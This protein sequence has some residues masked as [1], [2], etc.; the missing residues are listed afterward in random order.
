[1]INPLNTKPLKFWTLNPLYIVL[2]VN[3]NIFQINQELPIWWYVSIFRNAFL[4]KT[5]P[6]KETTVFCEYFQ[7]GILGHMEHIDRTSL[8][9]T[10]HN[11]RLL[12][13]LKEITLHFIAEN[14]YKNRKKLNIWK[15]Y[16]SISFDFHSYKL[17]IDDFLR[18]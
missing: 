13:K 6:H 14:I 3:L 16:S 2:C 11:N 18:K 15:L 7:K 10:C 8:N 4:H 5:I 12:N 17:T 1:M 9:H